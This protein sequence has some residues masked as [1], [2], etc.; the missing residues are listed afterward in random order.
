MK[1]SVELTKYQWLDILIALD[2]R[3]RELAEMETFLLHGSLT[4]ATH[5][6]LIDIS[7][8][9]KEQLHV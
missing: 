9:I 2:C 6:Y 4:K 1:L 3:I 8:D 5:R 7:T